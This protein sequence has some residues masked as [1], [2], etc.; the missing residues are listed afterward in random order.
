MVSAFSSDGSFNDSFSG[1]LQ[2]LSLD[3]P[4]GIAVMQFIIEYPN[5]LPDAL[6]QSAEQF[7]HEAKMAMAVK[8]FE[9]GRLSSGMAAQLVNMDR[10]QF[11]LELHRYGVAI[12]DL[13]D[14]ELLAD[15]AH[16]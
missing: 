6:Q 16:A 9:L 1:I 15:I 11:L 2:T 7:E 4:A 8:L 13:P 12:H 5:F 3:P 14:N 10:T